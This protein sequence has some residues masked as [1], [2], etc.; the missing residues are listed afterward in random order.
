MRSQSESP[1]QWDLTDKR[2]STWER[3][4][5]LCTAQK[6]QGDSRRPKPEIEALAPAAQASQP[7][8]RRSLPWPEASGG[9]TQ[10]LSWLLSFLIR[11]LFP[12]FPSPDIHPDRFLLFEQTKNCVSWFQDGFLYTD[13]ILNIR[14]CQGLKQLTILPLN[15]GMLNTVDAVGFF[16]SRDNSIF[17][18]C[19]CLSHPRG[20]SIFG[21]RNKQLLLEVRSEDNPWAFLTKDFIEGN[22]HY[23]KVWNHKA[24]NKNTPHVRA[25]YS[26]NFHLE[27]KCWDPNEHLS[28]VSML[29]LLGPQYL[30]YT[31]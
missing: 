5:W 7:P 15:I 13:N 16:F 22:H 25:F 17:L 26:Q 8:G 10:L 29:P 3:N 19:L 2:N 23:L 27:K 1:L 11:L 20:G 31:L 4:L 14:S 30:K 9:D 24:S 6:K 12:A 18:Y 21:S 28:T